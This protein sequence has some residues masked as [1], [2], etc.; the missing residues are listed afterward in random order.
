GIIGQVRFLERIWN[1]YHKLDLIDCGSGCKN[2]PDGMPQLLHKTIKKVSEDIGGLRFN[3]AIS[4]MMIFVNFVG[5]F[6]IMP[7][8]ATEK[9]LI[10]LAPFAP[11]LAEELWSELGHK[12]SIFKEKWPEYDPAMVKDETI[13]LVIQVNGKVRDNIE[14]SADI[15]EEEAEKI[16]LES[17]KIKKW[18]EKKE[19]KKVIFVKGK[20][21]NIVVK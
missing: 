7:R 13:N 21:V 3:T 10:I 18:L 8:A 5:K 9:F 19:V 15:S 17:E 6:K 20:L 1:L 4:Q 16:A 11:H 12:Q 14:V 2:V